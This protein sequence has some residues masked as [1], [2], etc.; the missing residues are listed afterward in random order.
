MAFVRPHPLLRVEERHALDVDRPVEAGDQLG[1]PERL[2]HEA[3]RGRAGWW[4]SAGP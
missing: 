1:H 3:R 2:A 4:R